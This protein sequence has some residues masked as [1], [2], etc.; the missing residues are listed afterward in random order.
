MKKTILG[1][2]THGTSRNFSVPFSVF[3]GQ[4]YFLDELLYNYRSKEINLSIPSMSISLCVPALS[5]EI[6]SSVTPCLR[7]EP[8]KVAKR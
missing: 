4:I 5:S 1:H 8:S 6:F 3:R 2:G 7:G